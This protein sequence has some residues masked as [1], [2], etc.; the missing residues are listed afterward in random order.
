[1]KILVGYTPSPE[2]VAAFAYAKE[3]ATLAQASVVVVNTGHNGN[4]ADPAFADEVDIDAIDAELTQADIEH[5]IRRPVDARPQPTPCSGSPKR[6][7]PT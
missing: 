1:M 5:E 2:G 4:Y 6:S 7:R 3:Q